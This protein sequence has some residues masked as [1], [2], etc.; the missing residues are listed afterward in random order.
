MRYKNPGQQTSQLITAPITSNEPK[1]P[2]FATAI[3]GFG[4]LLKGSTHIKN[5]TFEDAITLAT[6]TKGA[7]P[8]GYRSE[9]I[10]L[11]KLAKARR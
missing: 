11:M 10:R 4:Q 2:D 5:W 1:A 8:F 7:D 9:A 3:A 6:Q